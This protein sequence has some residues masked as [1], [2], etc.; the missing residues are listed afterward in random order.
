MVSFLDLLSVSSCCCCLHWAEVSCMLLAS[1]NL[2]TKST[3]CLLMHSAVFEFTR[4]RW[5]FIQHKLQNFCSVGFANT[6]LLSTHQQCSFWVQLRYVNL[7][8]QTSQLLCNLLVQSCHP[9]QAFKVLDLDAQA[10]LLMLYE[11][12]YRNTPQKGKSGSSHC[13]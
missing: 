9:R 1:W 7:E 12:K 11:C 2:N 13:P 4:I 5:H 3:S 10:R 6:A 8:H